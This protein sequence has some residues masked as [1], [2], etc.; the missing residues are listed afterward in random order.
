MAERAPVELRVAQTIERHLGSRGSLE[1]ARNYTPLN[2]QGRVAVVTGASDGIGRGIAETFAIHGANLVLHGRNQAR[3]EDVAEVA[4]GM[5]VRVETVTGEIAMPETA[6]AVKAV[7]AERY[8]GQTDILVN[9]AGGTRD[10]KMG[11]LRFADW[12]QVLEAHLN[13]AFLMA[14]A[15]WD[16]LTASQRARIINVGSISG[17]FGNSGQSNYSAAKAGLIGLTKA[18]AAELAP[19]Q[20][21]ANL[22]AYGPVETKIWNSLARGAKM[23]VNA[24]RKAKGEEPVAEDYDPFTPVKSRM[25]GGQ[26]TSVKEAASKALFV[27]SEMGDGITGQVIIVDAGVSALKLG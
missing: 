27:A 8:N 10:R 25:V 4:Q 20:G 23:Q 12:K 19:T 24:E 18:W 16:S 1:S 13:G 22:L 26:F 11:S 2:L 17:I 15:T 5:G 21:T 9:N 6:E 3:L 7:V 14:D